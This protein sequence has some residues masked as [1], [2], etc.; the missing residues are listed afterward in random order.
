MA[1]D[2]HGH[3]LQSVTPAQIANT[4]R[5]LIALVMAVANSAPVITCLA[6]TA[7]PVGAG[8]ALGLSLSLIGDIVASVI[9]PQ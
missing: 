6:D 9:G 8:L 5:T 1:V 7:I 3:P 4:I 2:G